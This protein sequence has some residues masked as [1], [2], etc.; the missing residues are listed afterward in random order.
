MYYDYFLKNYEA[1]FPKCYFI[2]NYVAGFLFLFIAGAD[3]WSWGSD[4]WCPPGPEPQC[5]FNPV[6]DYDNYFP[7]PTDCHYYIQCDG[8]RKPICRS[9]S[10]ATYFSHRIPNCVWPMD[11]ACPYNDT[12]RP[13]ILQ[14]PICGPD[15]CSPPGMKKRDYSDC[16]HYFICINETFEN[17]VECPK[18]K[19]F[20]T[21]INDCD[22][23]CTAGCI[24][25]CEIPEDQCPSTNIA[26]PN[27]CEWYRNSC[28]DEPI[29]CP[30]N[31]KFNPATR[32]CE[33]PCQ[34]YIKDCNCPLPFCVN[35]TI[36]NNCEWYR[37]NCTGEPIPCPDKLNFNSATGKCEDPCKV[38]IQ[39]CPC[40]CK[41]NKCCVFTRHETDCQL[42]YNNCSQ[43]WS[44][45]PGN[46][47]FNEVSQSCD[48]PCRAG[49]MNPKDITECC[50][51]EGEMVED[52]CSC[53]TYYICSNG[54]KELVKCE[55][56]LQYNSALRSCDKSC[57]CDCTKLFAGK[58]ECC[59]STGGKPEPQCP[60]T[61]YP[62]FLPHPSNDQFFYTC[63]KG[64]RSCSRCPFQ[65]RWNMNMDTCDEISCDGPTRN[66]LH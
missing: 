27:N 55:G 51:I 18:G 36:P 33:D 1:I 19:H 64:V 5:P 12:T 52:P 59:A 32:K 22:D 16:T 50:S 8:S 28:T 13:E 30:V 60:D 56:G 14:P 9:C 15:R 6:T 48:H 37:N 35:I 34:V 43:M 31:E 49:C 54:I 57:S 4:P 66:L 62:I 10:P 23:Q 65:H 45:C 2:R 46:L 21:E 39:D 29:P 44:R 41:P 3:C 26:I 63:L 11:A 24:N 47:H 20:N 40:E 42:Y 53:N 25:P 17:R 7:H 58:P 38:D 61:M